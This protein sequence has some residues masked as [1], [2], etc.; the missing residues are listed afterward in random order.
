[1]DNYKTQGCCVYKHTSPSNK[2]YIGMTT[3]QPEER[4]NNGWGYKK[5]PFF[6]A[7][8]K[9]GWEN[10]QHEILKDSLTLQEALDLERY[11]IALYNS[12]DRTKGY[13]IEIG[14]E[15]K[16]D[17]YFHIPI[18][19]Y[20]FD[21]KYEY[22]EN[23]YQIPNLSNR[24]R[25]KICRIIN[26]KGDYSTKGYIYRTERDFNLEK[27]GFNYYVDTKFKNKCKKV[28]QY[29]IDGTFLQKFD[30]M[31]E[32]QQVTGIKNIGMCCKGERRTCGGYVWRYEKD[33]FDKFSVEKHKPYKNRQYNKNIYEYNYYTGELVHIYESLYEF[34]RVEQ[35]NILL[36]LK[37]KSKH[38]KGYTYSFEPIQVKPQP[39]IGQFKDGLLINTYTTIKEA[40][41]DTKCGHISDCLNGRLKT[42]KGYE[43]KYV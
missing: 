19:R 40:K 41:D 29:A 2:V 32:A 30:S 23:I 34:P 10:F 8:L 6:N 4:W 26:G 11:Y 27:N 13:N 39:R 20:S 24:D 31:V 25:E 21:G 36:I 9:Y 22:Y 35:S 3:V 17:K 37:G 33:S 28:C 5:Q 42:S 14:G 7:I 43:W 12:T 16:T 38:N 18:Y 15:Y 1:M